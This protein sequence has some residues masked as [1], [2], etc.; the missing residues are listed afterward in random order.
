ML[1]RSS[2]EFTLLAALWGASFLFMRIAAPEF[3]PF[4]LMLVRC[5]VAAAVLLPLAWMIGRPTP[6]LS[7]PA[8]WR[9][10]GCI[11]FAGI[12][13]SAIPFACFG[14]SA[15]HLTAGVNSILNA[16]TPIF[17]AIVAWLWLGDRLTRWRGIGLALGLA[18]VAIISAN[19]IH[20][21]GAA[22]GWAVAAVLL[23]TVCYG[24]SGSFTRRFLSGV[25]PI[26]VAAGSQL[27]AALA[28]A[29]PGLAMWPS[30]APSTHAWTQ[31]VLLGIFATGLAYL[32]FF[33]LIARIGP[34]RTMTVTFLIPVFGVLWGWVFLGETLDTMTFA[35]G[36]VVL[37]GTALATGAIAPGRQVTPVV[38]SR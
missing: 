27:A 31:A 9:E 4:A 24:I 6:G 7:G 14:Y 13:N 8:R 20:G 37:I 3:G 2:A 11:G 34:A 15:L 10:A 21:G 29:W 26:R 17:G 30:Q 5:A 1:N 16:T 12:I 35:G 36:F 28:L 25:D 19:R 23:A 38:V 22:V 18:G 33:R 32:L